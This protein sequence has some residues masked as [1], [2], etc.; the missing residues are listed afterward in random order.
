VSRALANCRRR[1]R[2]KRH[3]TALQ[4][5][6]LHIKLDT[7]YSSPLFAHSRN[8]TKKNSSDVVYTVAA[9]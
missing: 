6:I 3:D 1:E 4:L 2:K 7:K 5:N 9:I 8:K